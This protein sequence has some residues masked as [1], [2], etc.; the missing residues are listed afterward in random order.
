MLPTQSYVLYVMF[1]Q[2]KLSG[3]PTGENVET[4]N[5]LVLLTFSSAVPSLI[6]N[7]VLYF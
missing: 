5:K 7:L 4:V 6:H 2:E 1:H 3:Q